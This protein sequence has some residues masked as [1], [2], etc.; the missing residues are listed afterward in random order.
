MATGGHFGTKIQS[1]FRSSEMAAG[2]HFVKKFKKKSCVLI[3]YGEKYDQ[4]WSR[5]TI[6]WKKNPKT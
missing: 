2:D 5:A 1:D 4:K 3:W 6:L